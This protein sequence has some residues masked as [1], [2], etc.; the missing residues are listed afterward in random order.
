MRLAAA[1]AAIATAFLGSGF[2]ADDDHWRRMACRSRTKG[3]DQQSRQQP[4]G[5][6]TSLRRVQ[7]RHC[8]AAK[9]L[10]SFL[11]GIGGRNQS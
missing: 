10:L 7:E 11:H 5:L 1:G 4:W 8:T 6:F 3:E 2:V 9:P